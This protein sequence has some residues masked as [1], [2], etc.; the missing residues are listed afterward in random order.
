MASFSQLAKGTRARRRIALPLGDTKADPAMA[1]GWSG[2]VTALDVRPLS[3]AKR[4]TSS[5]ARSRFAKERGLTE[6]GPE[7]ALYE[8]GLQLHRIALACIDKD[9]PEDKPAPFFDGGVEPDS[10][11]A[12]RSRAITS[13]T[14][15]STPSRSKTNARRACSEWTLRLSSRPRSKRRE[16]TCSLFCSFGRGTQWSFARSLAVLALSSLQSKSPSSSISEPPEIA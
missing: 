6:P 5:S 12:R 10:S 9:S 7:D 16:A 15:M 11:R 1:T 14:S 4:P 3:P 8:F 2:E 13:L